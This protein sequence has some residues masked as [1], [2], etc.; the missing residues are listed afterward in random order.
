MFE[1]G[2]PQH[3]AND[4]VCYYG[5]AAEALVWCDKFERR[6][7]HQEVTDAKRAFWRKVKAMKCI[8]R[9]SFVNLDNGRRNPKP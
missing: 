4:M 5:S 9:G 1:F 2:T 7:L 8:I 6:R 3:E